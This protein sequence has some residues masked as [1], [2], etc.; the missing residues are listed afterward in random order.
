MTSTL[1]TLPSPARLRPL[2]RG[3][4]AHLAYSVHVYPHTQSA[5]GSLSWR[6]QVFAPTM[7]P[8]LRFNRLHLLFL[9]LGSTQNL[10]FEGCTLMALLPGVPQAGVTTLSLFFYWVV[11]F[12]LLFASLRPLSF[13]GFRQLRGKPSH[14]VWV[15]HASNGGFKH[16]SR[17]S[18]MLMDTGATCHIVNDSPL[19]HHITTV[20]P[21]TISGVGSNIYTRVM[22]YLGVYG[23]A[24]YA[25]DFKHNISSPRPV[26]ATPQAFPSLSGTL[27]CSCRSA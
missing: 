17:S 27:K 3:V 26:S 4:H 18:R 1:Q 22:G 7:T 5:S 15:L 2:Q 23:P 12:L 20:D 13:R 11:L 9:T 25:K 14:Q 16:S 24:F 8:D 19:L 10:I 21:V 6:K